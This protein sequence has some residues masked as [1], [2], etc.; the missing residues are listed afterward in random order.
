MSK[1]PCADSG[2][3]SRGR[4]L[5]EVEARGLHWGRPLEYFASVGSTNDEARAAARRGVRSGALFVADHQTRGRGRRQN[6]WSSEAAE[7]LL[8]S[9]VVRSSAGLASLGASPLAFGLGLRDAVAALGVDAVR[10]KWPNDVWIGEAKAAGILV[11]SVSDGAQ[12]AL[13][14]GIGLNV[15]MRVPPQ[16]LDAPATSLAL[17][18]GRHVER[19]PLLAE[20]LERMQRRFQELSETGLG[21]L[22]DDLRRYDLLVGRRIEVD[23]Q[24]GVSRGIAADGSL[25]FEG[26]SG[27]RAVVA[28]TI[29]LLPA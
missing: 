19:E 13:I 3:F 22:V 6:S 26:D 17:A 9:I 24:R 1:G 20:V 29:T 27:E 2:S 5:E 10:I 12:T 11:E 8:F 21:A 4:F 16:R 7:N 14:V 25:R 28:G 18:L 15:N 23:G